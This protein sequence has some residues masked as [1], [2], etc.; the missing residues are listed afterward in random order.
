[1]KHALGRAAHLVVALALVCVSMA[2]VGS[3]QYKALSAFGCCR[4]AHGQ[5]HSEASDYTR[6]TG[7]GYAGACSG[8]CSGD[9]SCT[10]YEASH[11]NNYCEIHHVPPTSTNEDEACT[12]FIKDT[13]AA[14]SSPLLPSMGS[15]TTG[16]AVRS[17]HAGGSVQQNCVAI[18]R[19]VDNSVGA[20]RCGEGTYIGAISFVSLGN[21]EG[22]C[23]AAPGTPFSQDRRSF[24][25]G[26]CEDLEVLAYVEELCLGQDTCTLSLV[27]AVAATAKRRTAGNDLRCAARYS[28][29]H[30]VVQCASADFLAGAT[31]SPT[32]CT[33]T[34][35]RTDGLAVCATDGEVQITP[36]G[37]GA[38]VCYCDDA[39][40][41]TP[42]RPCCADKIAVCGRATQSTTTTTAT[43]TTTTT[44]RTTTV[45]ATTTTRTTTKTTQTTTTTTP[46]RSGASCAGLGW[47]GSDT[48]CG[49]T[50][51]KGMCHV[52]NVTHAAALGVCASVG[53]RLC[54]PAEIESKG[55]DDSGCGAAPKA[56]PVWTSE[57]CKFKASKS[58]YLVANL[59]VGDRWTVPKPPQC[60]QEARPFSAAC[61]ADVDVA[62]AGTDRLTG[63]TCENGVLSRHVK[64]QDG[65][66]DSKGLFAGQ[67]CCP[68]QCLKC[69]GHNCQ[70]KGENWPMYP[71]GFKCCLASYFENG[72]LPTGEDRAPL[73]SNAP[74][75]TFTNDPGLCTRPNQTA[76]K[77]AP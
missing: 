35:G 6:Y 41:W 21:G 9:A 49:A 42:G 56:R 68:R 5:R 46:D 76:C 43:T 44:T 39:C 50:N 23:D 11:A 36:T 60:K 13:A 31:C 2:D 30:V 7:D 12:C 22:S 34:C 17:Q 62:R 73:G 69:G 33:G 51:I 70:R 16:S 75:L 19:G 52:H 54:T 28:R 64:K 40:Q 1:M 71:N 25:L 53:A 3:T 15:N 77:V 37:C 65:L 24:S 38:A 45:T 59:P 18:K 74:Y 61:C 27:D 26:T 55:V 57:P 29:L 47:A 66:I 72:P 32:T 63:P 67:I 14:A 10:G 4:R 20:L 48:T 58:G 8:M